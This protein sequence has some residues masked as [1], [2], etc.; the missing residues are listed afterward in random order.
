MRLLLIMSFLISASAIA[1]VYENVKIRP[2]T[3][4]PVKTIK[5]QVK[6]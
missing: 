4:A 3:V 2:G 1:N 6:R 5:G